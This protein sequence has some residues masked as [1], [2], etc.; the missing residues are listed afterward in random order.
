MLTLMKLQRRDVVDALAVVACFG[1][2]T[3]ISN[4]FDQAA[5]TNMG[6]ALQRACRDLPLALRT[7]GDRLFI[8]KRILAYAGS[9]NTRLGDLTVVGRDAVDELL[10]RTSEMA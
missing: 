3:M 4:G 8:A 10:S 5:I 2:R 7:P 9:G 6:I 1:S